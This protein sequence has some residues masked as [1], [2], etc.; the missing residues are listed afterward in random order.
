[1]HMMANRRKAV[2]IDC[3]VMNTKPGTIKRFTPDDVESVKSL[4]H[5]SLHEADVLKIIEMVRE[6]GQSPQSIVIFG[7]EPEKIEQTRRLSPVLAAKL[8]EYSAMVRRE[9]E[10]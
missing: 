4:T 6:L 7:I 3:A 2:I 10:S 5:Y 8:D 1:M 9:I